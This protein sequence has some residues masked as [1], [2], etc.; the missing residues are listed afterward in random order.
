MGLFDDLKSK[1]SDAT[2]AVANSIGNKTVDVVFDK[3]PDSYEEFIA[4][5]QAAMA[6]P[7]DTAALTI[8]ALCFYPKDKELCFKML[9]YLRGPRQLSEYDKQFLRDR[10]MDNDYV[11]RSYFK[12][13]TPENDYVPAEPYTIVANTNPNSD[14]EEGYKRIFLTSGGADSQRYIDTRLAKDGKW[15]LWEQYVLSQ[16]RQ[17][18]SKNFWA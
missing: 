15:Y 11:A 14:I 5:P 17:P 18:E 6:T 12:G 3:L 2:N 13:A 4:L 1:I 7:F 16:I 10:F 8:L 9:N